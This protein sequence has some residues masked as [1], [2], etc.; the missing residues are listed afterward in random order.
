MYIQTVVYELYEEILVNYTEK[1]KQ[2]MILDLGAPVGLAGKD[3]MDRYLKEHELE[4][5]DMKMSECYQVFR[6]GPSKQYVSKVMMELPVIVRRMDG[7]E[8][9]LK[10][11]TYLVDADVPFLCGKITMVKNGVQR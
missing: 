5:R 3:W 7:K 9:V 6:F 8:D 1:G 4:M 11:F 2:V 10:I